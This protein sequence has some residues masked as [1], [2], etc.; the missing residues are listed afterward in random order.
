MKN[1]LLMTTA[2]VGSVALAGASFAET[3]LTGNVEMTYKSDS[4]DLAASDK[5]G[6]AAFG[7]ETNI[8]AVTTKEL[9]NG[10]SMKAGMNLE[11]GNDTDNQ[12]TSDVGY[13][14]VSSGNFSV[15]VGQDYGNNLNTAGIPTVGD[16]YID[17]S[18]ASLA[19]TNKDLGEEAH[20]ALHLGLAGKFE[21]GVAFLNYAPSS[22]KN[23]DTG[24]SGTT[25]DGGSIL[26]LGIKGSYNGL[27]FQLGQ[28]EDKQDND[29]ASVSE[30]K[31]QFYS[32][33]YAAGQFALGAS[34]RTYDAGGTN[35][36]TND[37]ENTAYG[38]TYAVNDQLSVGIQ[39]GEASEGDDT[40]DEETT[41]FSVG[42]S[43]G[44]MGL[45]FTYSQVDNVGAVSGEDSTGFQIRTVSKF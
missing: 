39:Y 21:G 9:D 12:A 24:D 1:K 26:E 14:E 36:S 13:V 7:M 27:S 29:S 40:V 17:A 15:H 34:K 28:Q 6:K 44:G 3:K 35:T 8:G 42:Y 23:D 43:L 38:V 20:D 25:D 22:A 30:A 2:L 45:E 32:V 41:A 18:A 4:R 33:G 16:N 31:Q 19:T 37:Y 11:T 10:M 5:N